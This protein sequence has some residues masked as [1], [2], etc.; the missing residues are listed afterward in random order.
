MAP[1]AKLKA[2]LAQRKLFEQELKNVE[3]FANSFKT[4]DNIDEIQSR[5][6]KLPK[7]KNEFECLSLAIIDLEIE[8]YPIKVVCLH[9]DCCKNERLIVQSHV[10]AII[11]SLAIIKPLQIC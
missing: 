7:I 10:Q 3:E 1:L 9:G 6:D 8:D 11:N 2:L 4:G 5:V